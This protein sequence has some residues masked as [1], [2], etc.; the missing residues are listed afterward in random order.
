MLPLCLPRLSFATLYSRLLK[1]CYVILINISH[2]G[3]RLFVNGYVWSVVSVPAAANKTAL[4]SLFA[5]L[6]TARVVIPAWSF[7]AGLYVRFRTT[8]LCV[9]C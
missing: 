1:C 5:P 7:P 9:C 8:T 2:V 3:L 6:N 4:D